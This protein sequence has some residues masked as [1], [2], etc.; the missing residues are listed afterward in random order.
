MFN[1]IDFEVARERRRDDLAN[2]EHDRLI[3]ACRPS[4][5]LARR[6][7]RPLGRAL[8]HLGAR[9]LSYAEARSTTA[10]LPSY[11]PSS[12]AH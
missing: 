7:A 2:A 1:R 5:A 10:T 6:A 12:R 4:F 3:L 9:L 8:H 11:R